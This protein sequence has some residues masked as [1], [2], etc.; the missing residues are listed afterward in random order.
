MLSGYVQKSN[1]K[2]LIFVQLISLT[3]NAPQIWKLRRKAGKLI[4]CKFILIYRKDSLSNQKHLPPPFP[5]PACL[6]CLSWLPGR[7]VSVWD[8]L[9]RAPGDS[10]LRISS[11]Q[12]Q[13]SARILKHK[14][15][16]SLGQ[17][18]QRHHPLGF[19]NTPV[20]IIR[21]SC[22]RISVTTL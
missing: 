2:L 11:I 15:D 6:A 18:G 13:P 20:P 3:L 4:T 7:L 17:P 14:S 10:V 16:S 8:R 1:N 9:L 19:L 5:A 21:E 12:A 22:L